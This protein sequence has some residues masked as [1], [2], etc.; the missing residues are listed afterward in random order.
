MD[1]A[2]ISSAASHLIEA[3][4]KMHAPAGEG[5]VSSGPS[6][7]PDELVRN[8]EQMLSENAGMEPASVQANDAASP[9]RSG[10]YAGDTGYGDAMQINAAPEA[11]TLLQPSELYSLQFHVAMLRFMTDSGSQVQQK[12]VQ[13]LDSLLRNQ[14]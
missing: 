3:F 7:V 13:G 9:V 11:H 2:A 5:L 8:F 10:Q 1:L 12:T 4:E 14:S 6:P